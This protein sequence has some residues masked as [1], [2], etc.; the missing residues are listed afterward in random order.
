V[1][2]NYKTPRGDD[3]K[4]L[5]KMTINEII[6]AKQKVEDIT[7]QASA[8]INNKNCYIKIG[9]LYMKVWDIYINYATECD[10]F[11]VFTGLTIDD[12]C[13]IQDEEISID[14]DQVQYKLGA[15]EFITRE[16]FNNKLIEIANSL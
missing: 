13:I 8:L 16:K 6:E 7:K 12:S 3:L 9:A 1:W 11:V 10:E 4:S 2:E 5:C 14:L 15:L